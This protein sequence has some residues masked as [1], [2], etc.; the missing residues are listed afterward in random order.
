MIPI[1]SQNRE[2]IILPA[3]IELDSNSRSILGFN[4]TGHFSLLLGSYDSPKRCGE[5]ISTYVAAVENGQPIFIM[6]EI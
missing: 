6:P 1:L 5:I 3:I 2:A 4:T